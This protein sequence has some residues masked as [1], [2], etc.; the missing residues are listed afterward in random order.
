M[1]RSVFDRRFEEGKRMRVAVK[2]L[3]LGAGLGLFAATAFAQV[4]TV[5]LTVGPGGQYQQISAAVAAADADTNLGNYYDIQIMPGTYTNDFPYVTR[6]M[7][8]EVDPAYAGRPVVLKATVALPNEKGIILTVASLTVNGLTFTGAQIANSLGGNGAG[9]RDQNT[10]PGATLMVLNSTF[11]GNQEG[12]LT[13]DDVSETITVMDSKFISNGNPNTS[14]FQHGLYVN[15]AGSLTVSNSLFCGQLIGHDIKSRAQ[16]TIV[17]A[18]QLYDGAANA[19]LGCNAG[20]S[21]LAIDVPNGGAAAI[22][23]NQIIQGAASQNYKMIDYGEEG[24][25][26]SNNILLVSGNGF[27]SS[28]TP[29]ATAIYDPDCVAAQLSK[30]TFSGITTIVNPANCAVYQ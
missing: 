19:A 16:V 14:Y 15:H 29:S 18:N 10:A 20:S 3:S 26:Y 12:I 4:N 25:A 17:D 24:L 21:S 23:G 22:S 11:T 2:L 28:G 30:N 6:P 8:I 27:T 1:R 9:I 5:V 7:T 13:G